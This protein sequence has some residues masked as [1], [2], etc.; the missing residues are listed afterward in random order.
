M[1]NTTKNVLSAT[2]VVSTMA[3]TSTAF[4]LGFIFSPFYFLLLI[5]ALI[6]GMWLVR[7][8]IINNKIAFLNI[9]II[10][11][12]RGELNN[13]NKE[14][15]DLRKELDNAKKKVET[16]SETIAEQGTN[17]TRTLGVKDRLISVQESRI[18]IMEGELA[19]KEAEIS[20]IRSGYGRALEAQENEI[21]KQG[22]EISQM[23][24]DL[25]YKDA[26]ISYIHSCYEEVLKA[27]GNKISLLEGQ[28]TDIKRELRIKDIVACSQDG[29]LS[30]L[31]SSEIS[32]LLYENRLEIAKQFTRMQIY[33]EKVPEAKLQDVATQRC[34]LYLN[35]VD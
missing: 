4:I 20:E 21:S 17:F 14:V 26:A 8:V 18:S 11:D 6:L 3:F 30:L 32:D 12:L 7:Q 9:E 23:K 15:E 34:L 2:A 10:K 25:T 1:S 29:K 22:Y 31:F 28:L 33:K 5:P 19:E 16:K 13:A 27:Q 24:Y 35:Q